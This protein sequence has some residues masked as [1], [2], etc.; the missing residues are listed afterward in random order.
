MFVLSQSQNQ[1]TTRKKQFYSKD[2]DSLR[3]C[4]RLLAY[5]ASAKVICVIGKLVGWNLGILPKSGGLPQ[6]FP[7]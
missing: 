6:S 5:S 1:R 4:L 7:M 2:A 3:V